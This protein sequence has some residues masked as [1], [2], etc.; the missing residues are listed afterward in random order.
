VS[1]K[2]TV[3]YDVRFCVCVCVLLQYACSRSF[4]CNNAL[5]VSLY[6]FAALLLYLHYLIRG[7]VVVLIKAS[8]R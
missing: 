6:P 4:E 8:V 1:N 7:I 3:L 5:F 2:D